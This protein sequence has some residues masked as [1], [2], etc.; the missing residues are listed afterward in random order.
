[1]KRLGGRTWVPGEHTGFGVACWG[2][3]EVVDEAGGGSKD[4]TMLK[5]PGP[6]TS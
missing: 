3:G 1:M 2:V 5:I 4:F 6:L